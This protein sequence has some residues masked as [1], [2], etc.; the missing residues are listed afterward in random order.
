MSDLF[1]KIKS[2]DAVRLIAAGEPGSLS[3]LDRKWLIIG[4]P[5]AGKTE[6]LNRL[7]LAGVRN[8]IDAD[9]FG[10]LIHRDGRISFIYDKDEIISTLCRMKGYAFAAPA[11][12]V[13]EL[14][15]RL[16]NNVL[17]LD[18]D[19]KSCYMNRVRRKQVNHEPGFPLDLDGV[20]QERE[21]LVRLLKGKFAAFKIYTVSQRVMGK[22]GRSETVFI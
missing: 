9:K 21:A 1:V 10:K 6:F 2:D 16:F 17:F 12:C 8:T 13:E 4:I 5:G 19:P 18:N 22:T 15:T 3:S 20:I 7:Y 14:P 11:Y